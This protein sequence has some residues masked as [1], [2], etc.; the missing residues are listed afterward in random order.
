MRKDITSPGSCATHTEGAS[1]TDEPRK[2]VEAVADR[3]VDRLAK[4]AIAARRVADDLRVASAHVE[5]DGVYGARDNASHLDV[6]D[7]VVHTDERNTPQLAERASSEC[8]GSKRRAHAWAARKTNDADVGGL[9]SRLDEREAHERGNM[10]LVMPS[11][12]ARK[13]ALAGTSDV[14]FTRI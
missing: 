3:N 5:H 2:P 1:L 10:F 8:T 14:R 12:L 6:P 11:C 7:A 9:H 13:K 4:H